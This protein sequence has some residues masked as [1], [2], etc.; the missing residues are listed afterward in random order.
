VI[1]LIDLKNEINKVIK[2]ETNED[3]S[4]AKLFIRNNISAGI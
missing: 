4:A 1:Q 3:E 2:I